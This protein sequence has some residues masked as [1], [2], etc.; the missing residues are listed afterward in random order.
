MRER[1][2]AFS[3]IEHLARR[4]PSSLRGIAREL[5]LP[6]SSV[7]RLLHSL[8]RER[9]VERTGGEEWGVGHSGAE[10]V[11]VDK[12]QTAAQVRLYVEFEARRPIHTTAPNLPALAT[13]GRP[14]HTEP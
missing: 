14:L 2:R 13:S 1:E 3:V 7:H 5:D 9:V 12:V 8:E 6:V 11:Y 10:V 4:G